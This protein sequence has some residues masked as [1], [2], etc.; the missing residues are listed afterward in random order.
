MSNKP[1]DIQTSVSYEP[2]LKTP[3]IHVH[4]WKD[5]EV[6]FDRLGS[7]PYIEFSI[8]GQVC[9]CG[10]KRMYHGPMYGW[11]VWGEKG[12]PRIDITGGVTQ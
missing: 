9:D 6:D 3:E 12:R 4:Q 1:P 2:D 8:M 5:P 7:R 10:A 11:T